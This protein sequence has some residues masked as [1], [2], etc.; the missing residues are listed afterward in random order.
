MWRF[1]FKS[2]PLLSDEQGEVAIGGGAST[3]TLHQPKPGGSLT[4]NE[5]QEV[6]ARV[7]N[8]T[9]E[10]LADM[11]IATDLAVLV[12]NVGYTSRRSPS[13][14]QWAERMR[15]ATRSPSRGA[16]HA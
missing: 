9:S 4:R 6:L 16:F 7:S 1:Q 3:V 15:N 10:Q 14:E 12:D 11:I 5:V 8:L 13:V 2:A